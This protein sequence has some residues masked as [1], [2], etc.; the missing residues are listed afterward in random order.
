MGFDA[1]RDTDLEVESEG[2][3]VL[4]DPGHRALLAG[5]TLDYVEYEQGDFR[6]IFI[7]PNDRPATPGAPGTTTGTGSGGGCGCK[8]G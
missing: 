5:M 7:N 1:V 4:V 3:V 6:F 2:V 8:G